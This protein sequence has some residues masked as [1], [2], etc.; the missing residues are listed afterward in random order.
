MSRSPRPEIYSGWTAYRDSA[1]VGFEGGALL[2][3]MFVDKREVVEGVHMEILV[4]GKDKD[5]VG[6]H[7]CMQLRG[8]SRV[9]VPGL[10]HL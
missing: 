4:I 10:G 8:Y 6:V 3:Q 2:N 5:N 1:V 9:Y 7:I